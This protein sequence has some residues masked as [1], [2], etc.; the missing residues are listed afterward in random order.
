ME[1]EAERRAAVSSARLA[2]ARGCRTSNL[3]ALSPDQIIEKLPKEFDQFK[4]KAASA[5]AP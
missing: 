4:P 5:K 1:G 3:F 2:R